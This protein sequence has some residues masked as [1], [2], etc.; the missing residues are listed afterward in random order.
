[1]N[2]H[3]PLALIFSMFLSAC[4]TPSEETS[5]TEIQANYLGLRQTQWGLLEAYTPSGRPQWKRGRATQKSPSRDIQTVLLLLIDSDGKVRDSSVLQSSG[6]A[7]GDQAARALFVGASF[8]AMTDYH[9]SEP[10]VVQAVAN[11]KARPNRPARG[12]R[13]QRND[14]NFPESEGDEAR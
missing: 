13:N 3:L 12:Q 7:E 5:S 9:S 2:R 10:Y 6:D 8:P 14:S 11:L 1:M 4:S